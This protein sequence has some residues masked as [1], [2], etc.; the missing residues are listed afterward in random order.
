MKQC[1][2]AVYLGSAW[3]RMFLFSLAMAAFMATPAVAQPQKSAQDAWAASAVPMASLTNLASRPGTPVFAKVEG[4]VTYAHEALFLRDATDNVYC[5]GLWTNKLRAGELVQVVGRVV[6]NPTTPQLEDIQI[7]SVGF[8]PKPAPEKVRVADLVAMGR[9]AHLVRITATV[10]G[11]ATVADGPAIVAAEGDDIVFIRNRAGTLPAVQPG[12]TIE[13]TGICSFSKDASGRTGAVR[14][15]LRSAEDLRVLKG[16]PYWNASRLLLALVCLA[17]SMA[18][19][20]IWGWFMSKKA[21]RQ[22][23]ILREQIFRKAAAEARLGTVVE[24]LA[25]GIVV[26]DSTGRIISSNSAASEILGLTSAQVCGRA[27]VSPEWR[28]IREDGSPF[29]GL[30]H[31]AMV[32]LRTGEPQEKVIMGVRRP[33]GENRWI[34]INSRPL[35]DPRTREVTGVVASFQDITQSRLQHEQL[36]EAN[37]RQKALLSAIPD[38]MVL[39]SRSGVYLDVYTNDPSQ[40]VAPIP[41]LLGRNITEFFPQAMV[42]SWNSCVEEAFRTGQVQV[43][44][45]PVELPGETRHFEARIVPCGDKLLN[46]VR[47]IT[48]QVE[49]RRQHAVFESRL[50]QARKM[51]SLGTFAGGIAHDFNNLLAVILGNASLAREDVPEDHPASKSIG[52][53]LKACHRA[54]DVVR[55]ILS[56][57][58]KR[59]GTRE[60]TDLGSV[61]RE[62]IGQLRPGAPANI[63]WDHSIADSLSPVSCAPAEIHQMLTNLGTNAVQALAGS[64]GRISYEVTEIRDPAASVNALTRLGHEP[65]LRIRVCDTGP[66]M[67]A[68]TA[69]RVFEPFFTTKAPGQGTGLGLAVVHGIIEAYNGLVLLETEPGRGTCFDI[70]LPAVRG[71]SSRSDA[72]APRAVPHG[73][74]QRILVVDDEPAV[75]LATLRLLKRAGFEGECVASPESALGLLSSDAAGFDLVLSDWTMPGMN[76]VQLA[77]AIRALGIAVPIV[78]LTGFAAGI[79]EEDLR[80]ARVKR[81]LVKP[82]DTDALVR[83]IQN[84]LES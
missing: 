68:A 74:G 32:T 76:G 47:N 10:I 70:Y 56:F 20:G 5:R 83:A 73:A 80:A 64:P 75:G 16:P 82:V 69:E 62:V 8:G 23:L 51:E 18:L 25:E 9:D 60:M 2:I 30:E 63:E 55:Q 67:D 72:V 41:S 31:P 4:V 44:N 77:S 45:Y 65:H 11:E 52:E 58:R 33:G 38:L 79:R 34:S 61:V 12:A 78:I 81:V 66:G 48:P 35:L 39:Q 37:Q 26:Q 19:A 43:L 36:G 40:L 24:S 53:I 17:V 29:P 59:G 54:T 28:T 71:R 50:Q 7:R 6:S 42:D 49:A 14:I 84:A 46:I 57:S 21:Q 1:S 13:A 3:L 27:S 15:M 22:A